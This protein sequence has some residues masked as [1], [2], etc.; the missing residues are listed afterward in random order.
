LLTV[1][2]AP[3]VVLEI[4]RTCERRRDKWKNFRVFLWQGDGVL[5]SEVVCSREVKEFERKLHVVTLQRSRSYYTAST[6]A[7]LRNAR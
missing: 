6:T 2:T 4:M 7:W 1:Q 5:G 3:F